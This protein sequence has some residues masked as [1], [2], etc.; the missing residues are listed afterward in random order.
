M[1]GSQT[2]TTTTTSSPT[3]STTELTSTSTSSTRESTSTST[4]YTTGS[5]ST[6]LT[7]TTTATITSTS[8]SSTIESTSTMTSTTSSTS[9][10]SSSTP[11][12]ATLV[13]TSASGPPGTIVSVSGANYQGNT[14]ALSAAPSGLFGSQSCSISAGSLSGSFGVSSDAPASTYTVTVQT[15]GGSRPPHLL[16]RQETNI[17]QQWPESR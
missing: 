16:S 1:V 17:R 8:T 5:T 11:A 4:S 12:Q 13:L 14:C 2:V 15:D 6:E 7:S 3:S 9:Y 10:T